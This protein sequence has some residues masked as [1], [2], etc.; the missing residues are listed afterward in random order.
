MFTINKTYNMSMITDLR[1]LIILWSFR[2]VTREV[3]RYF[4]TLLLIRPVCFFLLL[5]WHQN[6]YYNRMTNN[7]YYYYTIWNIL[8]L[9]NLQP[10][11]IQLGYCVEEKKK[12]LCFL[13]QS[14]EPS[15]TPPPSLKI[16]GSYPAGLGRTV[17]GYRDSYN[18]NLYSS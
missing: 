16:L 11:L 7:Y 15:P 2:S 14:L 8:Y 12:L 13:N 17:F 5:V 6:F 10:F 4:G 3:P 1:S 9:P 18:N